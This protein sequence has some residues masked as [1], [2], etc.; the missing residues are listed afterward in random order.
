MNWGKIA[1]DAIRESMEK[2]EFDDLPGKGKPL[3]L[4]DYFAAP[5]DMRA[6]LSILR[7]A[8]VLPELVSLRSDLEK[9]RDEYERS[10]DPGEKASLRCKMNELST[11]L[12]LEMEKY[13]KR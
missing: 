7:N 5:E 12:N 2:G 1:E 4:N 11:R 13:R 6:G 10:T 3:N 8:N 9:I